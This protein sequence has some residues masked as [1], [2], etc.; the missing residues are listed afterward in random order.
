MEYVSLGR[1]GLKVSPLCLGTMMFGGRTDEADSR[2]IIDLARQ[3]S[4]PPAIPVTGISRRRQVMIVC[5]KAHRSHAAEAFLNVAQEKSADD[6]HT[7][8]QGH[9]GNSVP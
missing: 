8:H 1:S 9:K 5:R 7:G 2:A 4:S 3:S 6:Q